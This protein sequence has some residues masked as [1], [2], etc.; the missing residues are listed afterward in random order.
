MNLQFF[1]RSIFVQF[2]NVKTEV[3][4]SRICRKIFLLRHI[5]SDAGYEFCIFK[6]SQTDESLEIVPKK[7]CDLHIVC[8]DIDNSIKSH[9]HDMIENRIS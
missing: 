2:L 4:F 9:H 1:D 7:G 8:L 5:L 3:D 6:I